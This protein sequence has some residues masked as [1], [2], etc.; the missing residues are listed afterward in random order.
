MTRT[1]S[2]HRAA[3]AGWAATAPKTDSAI[4][5]RETKTEKPRH[6]DLSELAALLAMRNRPIGAAEGEGVPE[7]PAPTISTNFRLVADNDNAPPEE[8]FGVDRT[9]EI[10][11][12][13]D[14]IE[15]EMRKSPERGS[16]VDDNGVSRKTVVRIGRL[17][18]S[19]G[20]QTERGYKLDADKVVEANIRMPVGGMLGGKEKSPRDR[21]TEDDVSRTNAHYRWMVQGRLAGRPKSKAPP[22]REER[23]SVNR[24]AAA[25]MLARAYANTPTLPEITRCPDGFPYGP[26]NLG[27][28]FTGG[29]KGKKGESGSQAWQDIFT[30][31]ENRDTFNRALEAMADKHVFAL[32]EALSA[33]SLAQLGEARGYKGRHAIDAGRR[34][35]VAANDNY[36]D[37]ME[38]ARHAAER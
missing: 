21:G 18:F 4:F 37:A 5:G 29:R 20:T 34:L 15:R 8:G 6:R 7:E 25:D 11:P 32:T 33:R 13:M 10:T 27:Q 24:A 23:L 2:E 3:V 28:L 16:Y 19:D 38:A 30:E 17:R 14:E 26:T 31:K 22:T 35:L 9:L 12:T 1:A 36:L